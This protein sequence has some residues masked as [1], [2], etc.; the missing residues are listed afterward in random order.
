MHPVRLG[1]ALLAIAVCAAPSPARPPE[2]VAQPSPPF[3]G[4]AIPEAPRQKQPWKPPAHQLPRGFVDALT[5]LFD[6][7]VADPR[8][9]EYRAVTVA[10]G[11]CWTGDAGAQATHAFVL[12]AR[13]GDRHRF[14]VCWNGLVYPAL[15]VGEKADLAADVAAAVKAIKAQDWL[16]EAADRPQAEEG[17]AVWHRRLDM[18]A[19]GLL[20]RVGEG[21]L[22]T[23]LWQALHAPRAGGEKPGDEPDP[24]LGLA[25]DW[26]WSLFD[27][28]LGA[29][30][31]GDD[32]PALHSFRLLAAFAPR[33]EAEARKRGFRPDRDRGRRAFLDFLDQ[34]PDLVADQE[35]R[36][37]EGPHAPVVCIGPGRE[38]DRDKRIAALIARL[39]E[40]SARQMSQPGGVSL[41]SDLV[42]E[43]LI[44]E[45]EPALE[46][47]LACFEKDD[48][49]TRSVHF[50]RDFARSRTVLAVHEAAYVAAS[51]ILGSSDFEPRATGD[52]LTRSGAATRK[53]LAAA[54]RAHRKEARRAAP[55]DRWFAVLADDRAKPEQWLNAAGA[56][57]TPD[58][59]RFAPGTMV[60]AGA[61]VRT[62]APAEG[63]P[64][65]VGEPLRPRKDPSVTGLMLKRAGEVRDRGLAAGLALCLAKWDEKAALPVL[66]AQMRRCREAG[67]WSAYLQLVRVLVDVGDKKALDDYV[68]WVPSVT[69]EM[70]G[71]DEY[72]IALFFQWMWLHPN[73]PG[74]AKAAERLFANRNSPWVPLIVE[75][76]GGRAIC[77]AVGFL[78]TAAVRLPSFRKAVLA[79]LENKGG[80]GHVT[81]RHDGSLDMNLK[82]IN[83]SAGG[84]GRG[85]PEVPKE[86][87]GKFRIC[88]FVAWKLGE[89][90]AGAPRCELYWPEAKRDAACAA[91]AAFL[92]RYGPVAGPRMS[93]PRRGRPATRQDVEA[94]KAVF[95]LE[96]EGET[97]V[98][99]L[100]DWPAE[101]RWVTLQ[102]VPY[103]ERV[104][105][106]RTGKVQARV[107]YQRDGQVYQAEEVWKDGEWHRYYGFVGSHQVARVPASEVEFPPPEPGWGLPRR[108]APLGSGFDGRLQGPGGGGDTDAEEELR[109]APGSAVPFTLDLWNRSGLGR[110]VPAPPAELVRLTLRYAPETVSRQGALVPKAAREADWVE[111]PAKPGAAWTAVGKGPLGPAQSA[112]VATM[113]LRDWFDL[114]K[115]GFYRVALA[116]VKAGAGDEQPAG[117]VRFSVAPG[118]G[119]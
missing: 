57:V 73:H 81:A 20:L 118:K 37:R 54:M 95:S 106:P 43:A 27:H 56:L 119:G 117:E 71:S 65:L 97:R 35:R 102:D 30:M 32:V 68:A 78:E 10:I 99:R 28:G 15:T 84:G 31:R 50:R 21:D 110:A 44:R 103:E 93:L 36:A 40:V 86:V 11:S 2:E 91:C 6:Q 23:R 24:Y 104:A 107:A 1:A 112:R 77:P 66:A 61:V 70:V 92:R 14:A 55:A 45:G 83:N 62:G 85:N 19:A 38:R 89:H 116:P 26:A 52:N 49:L 90:L 59:E 9:C 48:R 82:N 7:G 96:G 64:R 113:D 42:V 100:P 13:P 12:P 88:D 76:K 41:G 22:A 5:V 47:L 29:H 75:Q 53:E 111:V 114:G 17:F 69:P 60:W 51:A 94:G 98:V 16:E 3:D 74:M 79:E 109:L 108:W 25:S 101:A 87:R 105:D 72:E 115:P 58:N 39:D 80:E 18:L 4:K 67:Q 46:P 34:L 8:G 63:K 33:A